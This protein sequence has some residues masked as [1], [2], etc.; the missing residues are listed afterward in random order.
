VIAKIFY[1]EKLLRMRI[2]PKLVKIYGFNIYFAVFSEAIALVKEIFREEC[3]ET[4]KQGVN[5]IIDV[6]SNIGISALY[7][8]KKFP[9]AK[10]ICFEP[11]PKAFEILCKNM[12]ANNKTYVTC[13]NFGLGKT[14]SNLFL[15]SNTQ[16]ATTARVSYVNSGNHERVDIKKL[17]T[18]INEEVGILKI[19]TEGSEIEILDDLIETKKLR[20]VETI[21]VEFHGDVFSIDEINH[22]IHEVCMQGFNSKHNVFENFSSNITLIFTRI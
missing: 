14:V 11:S 22:K 7:F 10:I 5:L 17:S 6:G 13:H 18:Y 1:Y 9:K 19:D 12:M 2:E 16:G 15:I 3:Y 4:S 20:L 21:I 8:G